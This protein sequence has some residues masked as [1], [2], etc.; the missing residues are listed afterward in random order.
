MYSDACLYRLA[1]GGADP[2]FRSSFLI[3]C[4]NFK[5]RKNDK[6][7]IFSSG[8]CVGEKKLCVQLK[9]A[10]RRG[11]GGSQYFGL[12]VAAIVLLWLQC[13]KSRGKNKKENLERRLSTSVKKI[14]LSKSRE[15][16]FVPN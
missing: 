1:E 16:I 13:S 10:S 4:Q 14:L 6:V 7:S 2:T 5:I 15:E 8:V 11:G 12:E 3:C 9:S